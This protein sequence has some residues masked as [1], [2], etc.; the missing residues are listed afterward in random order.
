MSLP[1]AAGAFRCSEDTTRAFLEE[2]VPSDHGSY[3]LPMLHLHYLHERAKRLPSEKMP[4]KG[5]RK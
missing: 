5:S 3:V 4:G 1:A 2:G